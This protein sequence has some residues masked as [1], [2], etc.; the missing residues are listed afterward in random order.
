MSLDSVNAVFRLRNAQNRTV[1]SNLLAA[2]ASRDS[3]GL[4][5]GELY[6]T[7]PYPAMFPGTDLVGGQVWLFDSADIP[8]VI[9][10][11]DEVEEYRPD[12][13]RPTCT[14]AK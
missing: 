5:D 13:S 8:A 1:S 2:P 7:G 14:I 9:A 6:D 3:T 4:D 11:L 12:T 10:E